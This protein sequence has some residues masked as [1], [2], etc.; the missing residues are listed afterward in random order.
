MPMGR[1]GSNLCMDV[2][3]QS[4]NVIGHNEPLTEIATANQS[5]AS[6]EL[7]SLQEDCL[8]KCVQ[9]APANKM[10]IVNVAATS[11][12]DVVKFSHFVKSTQARVIILDRRSV[13]RTIISVLRGRALAE[14]TG[15]WGV[16]VG[17]QTMSIRPA[18]SEEEMKEIHKL[19]LAGRGKCAIIEAENH[20]IKY[21][22]EDIE[23]DSVGFF[24]DFFEKA[25]IPWFKYQIGFSK[26]GGGEIC[27]LV[28]NPDE[29]MS[30]AEKF[31]VT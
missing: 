12:A 8:F 10:P 2:L 29:V 15:R 30:F 19:I 9:A 24:V 28:S 13:L 4:P 1:V 20:A 11:V 17:H 18:V 5:L 6:D 22:Y 21:F 7:W 25:S 3:S 16:R 31:G 14:K 27:S 23:V 26:F